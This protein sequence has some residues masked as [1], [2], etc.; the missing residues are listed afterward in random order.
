MADPRFYDN[1]GP[2]TLAEVCRAVD[3]AL[4][5]NAD[6][7]A[8][9]HDLASLTGA[10]PPHLTFYAG[11]AGAHAADLA[12]TAAGFCFVP[13]TTAKPLQMRVG[14]LAIP[15]PSVQHA[16]AAA[17][18]IFY[19]ESSLVAWRQQTDVD[20]TATIGERVLLA[21]GV[22]IGPGAEIGDG[23]RLS[24]NV[25]IGR[26]VAIGR[27]CEIGSNVS[28]THAY[29]GDEVLILPGAQIGQPGF[30]FAS[31]PQGHVKIPQIGRVIIQDRVEIGACTT[32]D[33][34]ALGDT[35]IG[36]GS[37]LDNLIQIG[38]NTHLGRHDI[39]VS[40]AGVAGSCE[41]GDFV[42]IGPQVGIADH[43]KIGSGA[44]VA[45]R[46]ASQPGMTYEGGQDYGGAPLRPVRE[47]IREMHALTKLAKKPKR[48]DHG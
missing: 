42:V 23:T 21:P 10:G 31:G 1:R 33:R 36:E 32:I 27:N 15:A 45:A 38:H 43:V 2:F 3:V 48:D 22:V 13:A 34:G 17:A 30:G 14:M 44:R 5:P 16:F 35:V 24:P 40:Q 9:V 4:P 20:P 39:V 47:W 11:G 37:K 8:R 19:P 26:G 41:F 7:N 29:I 12:Q 6:A 46:A 18:R 28:I 25:V